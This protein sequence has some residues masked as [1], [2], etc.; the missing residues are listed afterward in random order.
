MTSTG[1]WLVHASLDV[2]T[3]NRDS[4]K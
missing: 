4:C 3:D 1:V 2:S